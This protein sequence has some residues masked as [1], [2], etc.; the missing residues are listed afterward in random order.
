MIS[1]N[2]N[3]IKNV[4]IADCVK[5]ELLP[6]DVFGLI[7]LQR[8]GSSPDSTYFLYHVMHASTACDLLANLLDSTCLSIHST[9]SGSTVTLRCGLLSALIYT[10]IVSEVINIHETQYTI[11]LLSCRIGVSND[12]NQS[13]SVSA[14]NDERRHDLLQC[15]GQKEQRRDRSD[16]DHMGIFPVCIGFHQGNDRHEPV[17]TYEGHSGLD[18]RCFA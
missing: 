8:G 11:I 6:I 18:V 5:K 12:R 15:H 9:Q 3:I 10:K 14:E 2:V 13:I 16:Q 1:A 17:G 4:S 7:H